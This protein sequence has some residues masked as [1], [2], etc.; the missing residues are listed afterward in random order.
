MEFNKGNHKKDN[1]IILL[2]R[3]ILAVLFIFSSIFVKAEE[4]EKSAD[5]VKAEAV[6]EGHEKFQPGK[7]IMGHFAESHEWLIVGS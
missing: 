2:L 7:L 4:V 6:A 1:R 3:S 5:S